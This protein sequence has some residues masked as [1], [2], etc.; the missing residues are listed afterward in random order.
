MR[1]ATNKES[2]IKTPVKNRFSSVFF[3]VTWF[4][5][6]HFILINTRFEHLFSSFLLYAIEHMFLCQWHEHLQDKVL[7][8]IE[9][10]YYSISKN[11][12]YKTKRRLSVTQGQTCT[13]NNREI[14]EY[15]KNTILKKGWTWHLQTIEMQ[16]HFFIKFSSVSSGRKRIYPSCPTKWPRAIE[17]LDDTFNFNEE[18]NEVNILWSVRLQPK[19]ILAEEHIEEV[20]FRSG[21]VSSNTRDLYPSCKVKVYGKAR[22]SFLGISCDQW[23]SVQLLRTENGKVALWATRYCKHFFKE[24]DHYRLQPENDTMDL[25]TDHVNLN[26]SCGLI[27]VT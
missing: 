27:D 21:R 24:K 19:P 22:V 9:H 26:L 3:S 7:H 18:R 2:I 14:L 10:M 25:Y 13:R 11:Y 17:I 8:F 20:I 5:P 16:S 12:Y 6:T 4:P 15:I 23:N 1:I